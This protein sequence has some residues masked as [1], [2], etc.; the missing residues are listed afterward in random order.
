MPSVS[1]SR[2]SLPHNLPMV[3]L[4]DP[5]HFAFKDL[6]RLASR[7][8]LCVSQKILLP[9][10]YSI[11]FTRDLLRNTMSAVALKAVG[12]HAGAPGDGFNADRRAPEVTARANT[13]IGTQN[14]DTTVMPECSAPADQL[15][16]DDAPRPPQGSLSL[17]RIAW[18]RVLGGFL[19]YFNIWYATGRPGHCLPFVR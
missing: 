2:L 3:M 15:Q 17:G 19:L 7:W 10:N 18:L 13:A 4:V 14:R 1:A 11:S 8:P 6:S 16:A 9:H 12:V 5:S